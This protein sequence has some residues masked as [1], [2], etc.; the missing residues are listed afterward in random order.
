MRV[1]RGIPGLDGI[2]DDQRLY[3][4]PCG[5]GYTCY[6]FDNAHRMTAKLAEWLNRPDLAPPPRK[7]TIKAW[8]AYRAAM[9]AASKRCAETGECPDLDPVTRWEEVTATGVVVTHRIN[10]RLEA[11]LLR[12][13]GVA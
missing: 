1:L 3:V 7:G 4:I 5:K 8:R 9:A 11:A 12:Q 10:H 13:R 2:N 6:G